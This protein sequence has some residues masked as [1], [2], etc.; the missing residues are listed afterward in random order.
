VIGLQNVNPFCSIYVHI[1][2][3]LG[4]VTT[5]CVAFPWLKVGQPSVL[6]LKTSASRP[7]SD[8]WRYVIYIYIY[9]GFV[10][11]SVYIQ[12][13]KNSVTGLSS[14]VCLLITVLKFNLLSAYTNHND[15]SLQLQCV[16]VGGL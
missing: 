1:S 9:I 4:L 12:H 3:A 7:R 2:T 15:G 5:N 16:A 8:I 11:A 6:E 14:Q 13:Y 10:L